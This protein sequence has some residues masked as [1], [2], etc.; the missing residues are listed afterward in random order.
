MQCADVL[1]DIVYQ[2]G[3]PQRLPRFGDARFRMTFGNPFSLPA[4]VDFG[5]L[6]PGGL[7]FMRPFDLCP[8]AD[9]LFRRFLFF[10]QQM[11]TE[12]RQ[13]GQDQKDQDKEYGTWFTFSSFQISFSFLS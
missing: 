1:T 12:K 5:N 11:E 9:V 13:G 8:F 3:D 7:F 2:N 10:F 6:C 4:I